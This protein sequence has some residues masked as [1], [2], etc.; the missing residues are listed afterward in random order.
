[1]KKVETWTA[2]ITAGQLANLMRE[3]E[4]W[5]TPS[6]VLLGVILEDGY[7][8]GDGHSI[9]PF[10]DDDGVGCYEISAPLTFT[11]VEEHG[12]IIWDE[13]EGQDF[14]KSQIETLL[15]ELLP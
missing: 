10:I 5:Q 14:P 1:M 13:V 3:M 12:H 9:Y 2:V 7:P 11:G 6:S 4:P 8:D 15:N